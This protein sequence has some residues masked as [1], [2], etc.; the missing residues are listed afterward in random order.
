MSY[1]NI[2]ATVRYKIQQVEAILFSLR[3]TATVLKCSYGPGHRAIMTTQG[4]T[5]FGYLVAFSNA[6][7]SKVSDVQITLNYALLSCKN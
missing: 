1:G 2:I 7:G 3:Q 4:V 5:E 6:G